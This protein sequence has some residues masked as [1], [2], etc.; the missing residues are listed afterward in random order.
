M[1][2]TE[3][4]NCQGNWVTRLPGSGERG[5]SM[6]VPP[7]RI[8]I[9]S[10]RF[11]PLVGGAERVLRSLSAALVRQGHA[12]TLLTQHWQRAWPETETLDGFRVV[13]LPA[14]RARF[15]GTASYVRRLGRRL[16]Q[17]ADQ[18]DVVYV[19]MLKHSAYAAVRAGR[20]CGLPVVLRPEC[21]GPSGDVHWQRAARFGRRIAAVCRQADGVV[22][23]SPA[24]RE[25]LTDAGYDPG[26]I[27][28]LPNGVSVPEATSPG[29]RAAA[30]NDLTLGPGPIAVFTGRLAPQ[31]NL[32]VLVQAWARVH[33][34]R[35]KAQLV[36]VG[37]GPE[38][39]RLR[40]EVH[41]LHLATLVRFAGEVQVVDPYLRAADVFVL[42][43]RDEGMSISLLEAMAHGL[44]VVASDIPGN[45]ALVEDGVTGLLTGAGSPDGVAA[46]I[47][48]TL[49]DPD[50]A[51]RRART[52]RQRVV[53][54]YSIDAV[55]RRHAEWFAR[56]ACA[57]AGT[58]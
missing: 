36:L 12:V 6:D 18:Y 57:R 46:A 35:P 19:S 25:E 45:R 4:E 8:A 23:I 52:A 16:R 54:N 39:A 30:R 2:S 31:K 17:H 51:A 27:V 29:Q 22:A 43:S 47:E 1:L 3:R 44:P 13:R 53:D 49:S 41:G 58:S 32:E 55:A 21:S 15:I 40:E 26:R 42:P 37:D 56:L 28:H 33:Q 34:Q 5:D 50:A 24:I 11:W 9:V 14:T 10:R 48:A 7:L 20:A 38:S